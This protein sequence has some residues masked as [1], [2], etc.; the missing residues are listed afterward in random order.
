MAHFALIDE[1]NKVINVAVI[2]N[3]KLVG[4]PQPIPQEIIN[5]RAFLR[6]VSGVWVQTSY[7]GEFRK[8]F[9]GIGFT[10]DEQR[11]AFIS[12]KPFNS[13]VLN[14]AT[15][16]WESPVPYPNDGQDY[17]W[18]EQTKNWILINYEPKQDEINGSTI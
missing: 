2:S 10:Y 13:W 11:D 1:N 6:G 5:N 4:L 8:N 17:H 7:S 3:A 14:E 15:C 18:N 9:A 16:R 12:P